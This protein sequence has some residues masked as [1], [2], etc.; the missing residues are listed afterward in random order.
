VSLASLH[1]RIIRCTKCERLVKWR[2]EIALVKR[3]AYRD[4]TYWGRPVPGFGDPKARLVIVGLAPGAHGAN[5]TGRI[6][7]G[8]ASGAST[9][10][11]TGPASPATPPAGAATSAE[12]LLHHLPGAL[13]STWQQA[14]SRGDPRL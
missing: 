2:T 13:R 7:T 8:D 14:E 1:R 6:F 3:R 9:R 10:R 5:R 12:G 11:S 4:E